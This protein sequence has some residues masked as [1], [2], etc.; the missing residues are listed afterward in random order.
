MKTDLKILYAAVLLS[1]GLTSGSFAVVYDGERL[2]DGNVA[3]S[4]IDGP[5]LTNPD[6]PDYVID[7]GKP[8]DPGSQGRDRRPIDPGSQGRG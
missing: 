5:I 8:A 3:T 2:E 4:P 7:R 1:A 6:G